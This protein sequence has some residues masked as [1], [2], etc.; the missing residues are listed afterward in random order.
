MDLLQVVKKGKYF[1]PAYLHYGKKVNVVCD[2]CKRSNLS[3]CIGHDIGDN[4]Y[5]LCLTCVDDL[6]RLTNK[7]E[8][9]LDKLQKPEIR[10]RMMQDFFGDRSFVGSVRTNMAQ[11]MFKSEYDKFDFSTNMEQEMFRPKSG[12]YSFGTNMAQSMFNSRYGNA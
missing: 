6:D 11:E 5:D 2:R 8:K 12:K 9:Q 1:N 10:T 7:K 4:N 3:I